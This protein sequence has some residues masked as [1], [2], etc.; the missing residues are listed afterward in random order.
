MSSYTEK[1]LKTGWLAPNGRFYETNTYNHYDK[2]EWIIFDNKLQVREKENGNVED[3][4]DTL[5]RYGFVKIS[6]SQFNYLFQIYWNIY[7]RLTLEQREFLKGYMD[8]TED[9]MVNRYKSEIEDRK[10]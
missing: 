6:I 2:A 9:F 7:W 3:A 10:W 5:Y 4:D 8:R 1:K